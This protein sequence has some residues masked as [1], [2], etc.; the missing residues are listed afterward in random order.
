MKKTTMKR[1]LAVL[2]AF[3]LLVV[4]GLTGCGKDPVTSGG[5]D[6]SDVSE[7]VSQT[8]GGDVSI[9]NTQSSTESDALQTDS[10][11]TSADNSAGITNGKG[12]TT[13]KD[14]T[15]QT[16]TVVN[17]CYT[18]GNK[19]AKD[20]VTLKVM[21][22]DHYTGLAK[23]DNSDFAKYLKENFNI[24]LKFEVVSVGAVTEK[25]SLAYAGS[26]LPDMF[27]G[28][29]GTAHLHHAQ[30]ATKRVVNLTPY[31]EKYGPNIQEM[32]DAEPSA[33]YN[34]LY[35]DGN[36]YML[37]MVREQ[38]NYSKKF[39]IN[40]TW[41]KNLKLSMPTTTDELYDVLMAFKN[42]DANKNGKTDDE[43]PMII[44]A[45]EAGVGQIPLSLFSPF[46]VYAYTDRLCIDPSTGKLANIMI[47]DAYR[48]GLRYYRKLYETGLLYNAF[49]G[50]TYSQIKQWTGS[51]VQTVGVMAADYFGEVVDGK[52]FLDNYMVMA[53]ISHGSG[54]A[55]W[56][57]TPYE[58]IWTDW[59]VLT[60][61]CKYPEIA[62]RLADW[63]YSTEGTLVAL[64][65]PPSA[66]NYW[67]YDS[68]GNIV[69]NKDCDNL[70]ELTPSYPIPHYIG[71]EVNALWNKA[72]EATYSEADKTYFTQ[73]E[74]ML[75][76]NSVEGVPKFT[77]TEAEN[78]SMSGGGDVFN[79]GI[80]MQ[81][82]FIGGTASLDNDWNSYVK[83]MNKLGV[84]KT[85]EVKQK[86]YNRYLVWLKNNKK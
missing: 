54:K 63:L 24:T 74:T 72:Q 76:K 59:F 27:W 77:T 21:I 86:A 73:V 56:L 25:T 61:T 12:T 66:K 26:A 50:A 53:P 69:R 37:P 5:S 40:K 39:F 55:A 48:E 17:N 85:I 84:A 23:Y 22:R 79:Y 68:K 57:N 31:I 2:L 52:S 19:I 20:P 10:T 33:A 44:A 38:D 70:Y 3:S 46:G 1:L 11:T 28:M 60:S 41:L 82:N 65:G 29:A 36:R 64:Y 78:K 35:D 42:Q 34:T 75:G 71:A 47:T 43:I 9:D 81:W 4:L 32:L 58:D 51:S 80:Q 6:M 45:G 16:I 67:Y 18:G 13:K 49:R 14:G 62:V 7:G 30:V 83:Q 15:T 8:P